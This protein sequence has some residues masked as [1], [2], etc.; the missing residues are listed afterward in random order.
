MISEEKLIHIVHVILDGL[1]REKLVTYPDKVAAVRELKRVGLQWLSQLNA[2]ADVAAARI[3]SQ[4]NAPVENSPQW[5]TL[6]A[7]Y[8]EEEMTKRGG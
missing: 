6:F 1:E 2:V 5:D 4:K 3:R 7:K 8:C